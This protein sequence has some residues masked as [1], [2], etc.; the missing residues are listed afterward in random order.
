MP[1]ARPNRLELNRLTYFAAV[2]EAGALV[3]AARCGRDHAAREAM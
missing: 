2:V 3:A 1:T